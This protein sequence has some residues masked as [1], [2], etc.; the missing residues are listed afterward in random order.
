MLRKDGD[1][2]RREFAGVLGD[3]LHQTDCAELTK[4]VQDRA[5]AW[6]AVGGADFLNKPIDQTLVTPIATLAGTE[7]IENRS[8]RQER[9]KTASTVGESPGLEFLI[10]SWGDVLLQ[11]QIKQVIGKHKHWGIFLNEQNQLEQLDT[12]ATLQRPP[13]AEKPC[14]ETVIFPPPPQKA[15][16]ITEDLD[17]EDF[18]Y[19]GLKSLY[20]PGK[21]ST[22]AV[23]VFTKYVVDVDPQDFGDASE[24]FATGDRDEEN[25]EPCDEEDIEF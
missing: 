19:Q 16:Q 13:Q 10:E 22:P 24:W 23:D 12:Y 18:K 14:D 21:S 4:F 17:Y 8:Y 15:F 1:A 9:L 2:L 7:N 25:I 6:R 11:S 5:I 20:Q 3:R